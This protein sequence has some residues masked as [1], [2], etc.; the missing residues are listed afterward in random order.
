METYVHK[1]DN[2]NYLNDNMLQKK[3]KKIGCVRQHDP[4]RGKE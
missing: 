2:T 1:Q 3:K 4:R